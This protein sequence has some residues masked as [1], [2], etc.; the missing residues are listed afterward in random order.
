MAF[1]EESSL[2]LRQ[3]PGCKAFFPKKEGPPHRYG[4]S[5]SECWAAFTELL[6]YEG[7]HYGY[8]DIHRL[9]VDAYAVQH[10]QNTALQVELGISQRLIA[11]SIKSVAIHLI[12]LYLALVKK[13]ELKRINRMMNHILTSGAIFDPLDPPSQLGSITV[14]DIAQASNFE[15]YTQW[16]WKW[17]QS[18]WNAWTPHHEI[19]QSWYE[20][21]I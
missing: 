14:I 17:V 13:V 21:Y 8:P 20:K 1:E 2:S 12:A 19:V 7:M 6:A 10:P 15:E 3:C 16:A 4:V 11:A 18:A 9:V 5:S